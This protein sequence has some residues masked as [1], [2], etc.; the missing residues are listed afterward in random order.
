MILNKGE[1][2]MLKNFLSLLLIALGF[3]SSFVNVNLLSEIVPDK[4][5]PLMIKRSMEITPIEGIRKQD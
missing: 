4:D 2:M 5:I 3:A 1:T